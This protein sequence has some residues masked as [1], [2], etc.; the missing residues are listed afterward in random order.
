MGELIQT[1]LMTSDLARSRP[2]YESGLDLS[3]REEGE[4]S[5]AYETGRC[6]LKLQADFDEETLGAFNLEPPGDDRGDGAIVV[7]QLA[8]ELETVHE[9]I[10]ELDDQFGTALTEPREVPWGGRMFLARDPNGYV[11]ELRQAD[12]ASEQ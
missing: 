3:P 6:E 5:V 2:F 9:R 4:S 1:Y 7:I 11:Y 10:E 8:E 12:S